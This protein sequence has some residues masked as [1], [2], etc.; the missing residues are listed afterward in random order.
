MAKKGGENSKKAVGNARKAEAAA[1]K[2]ATEDQ[3]K[4]AAEDAKWS[5]GSKSNA[6]KEEAEARKAEAQRKKAEKAAL[7]AEEE[8]SAPSKPKGGGKSHV[9]TKRTKGLDLSQLDDKAPS[10]LSA[11]NIEDALD[12]LSLTTESKDKVD[13]HPERRYAAAFKAYEAK[14]MPELEEEQKGLR[15]NQR[16]EII[17]KEFEK[18]PLNPFNQENNVSF[19]ATREEIQDIREKN[20]SAKENR[21]GSN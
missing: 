4:S 2:Q 19:D 8:A 11:H 16:T 6:K 17:R 12:A 1:A 5:K 15:R 18:S 20:K 21:L 13:R 3:K 7:L 14:R 10:A 9:A